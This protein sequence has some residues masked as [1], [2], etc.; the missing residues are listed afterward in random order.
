MVLADS[1]VVE[2][3]GAESVVSVEL[4]GGMPSLVL[5]QP[6]GK[7]IYKMHVSAEHDLHTAR[8][9]PWVH[10]TAVP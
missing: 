5:L 4:A 6:W 1:S 3:A 8:F 7:M 10:Y 9:I 2:R